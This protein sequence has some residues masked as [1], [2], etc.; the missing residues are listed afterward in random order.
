MVKMQVRARGEFFEFTRE[1]IEQSIAARFASQARRYPDRLAVAAAGAKLSYR[2]LDILSDRVASLLPLR[3]N[4]GARPVAVRC[5][6]TTS[7]AAAVLGV[8]K[9]G[10]FYVPLSVDTPEAAAE[11]IMRQLDDPIVVTEDSVGGLAREP[12]A[13]FTGSPAR[14]DDLAYVYFTSGTTGEPKGVTDQHRNVLHNIMRYTNGLRIGPEDRLS[15]LQPAG[16]SGAVSSLFSAIL[17]GAAVFPFDPARHSTREL[18]QWVLE[19]ELT[20]WHSVPSLFRQLCSTE[21]EFPSVRVIRLEGD[22]ASP[23]DI[24]LFRRHFTRECVLVNGLGATETGI[25]RR[26]VVGHDT[27]IRGPLLPVGFAVEDMEVSV[28]DQNGQRL[29]PGTI[30]EVEVRSRYLATGYWRRPDLTARAFRDCPGEPGVRAYRTGDLGRMREDGCLELTGRNDGLARLRGQWVDLAAI[31]EALARAP[32]VADAA[33]AVRHGRGGE[34]RLTAWIVPTPG[35]SAKVGDLRRHLAESLPGQ[36]LPSSIAVIERIPLD[37]HG[38]RDRSQLPLPGRER[39]LLGNAYVAPSTPEETRIAASFREILELDRVGLD[40]DFFELGGDSLDAARMLSG[41]GLDSREFFRQPSVRHLARVGA[42]RADNGLIS[43]LREGEDGPAWFCVPGHEGAFAGYVNL[44]KHLAPGPAVHA[45]HPAPFGDDGTVRSLEA[46]AALYVAELRSVQP[47]GPYRLS[48]LCFGGE[49][50]YEMACQLSAA[51][52]RVELLALIECVRE[53]W[54]DEQ[55]WTSRA[56]DW[57][58][59][60]SRRGAYHGRLLADENAGGRYLLSRARAVLHDWRES[61]QQHAFDRHL[62]RSAPLPEE[63]R[64][65]RFANRRAA[66]AW[67]PVPYAGRTL[68]F[69]PAD[70][71]AGFFDAP[72]LG[73]QGYLRGETEVIR[74]SDGLRGLLS[75]PVVAAIAER[76]SRVSSMLE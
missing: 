18:A 21:R 53:S 71:R 36:P 41:L 49:T 58:R 40:D 8:L 30:G 52:E 9:A 22:A 12:S 38:K 64:Q 10:H 44:A 24:E 4:G 39:P 34:P 59:H 63:L 62:E 6:Q 43:T 65:V 5:G 13:R 23:R 68:L 7:L 11:R 35:G 33:A 66:L 25:T 61:A 15:L 60:L 17:N 37:R 55:P 27:A 29:S 48:G 69:A 70:P 19:N 72:M 73:W 16:F 14:P 56:A 45:F 1:D 74:L 50:A 32:G 42:R 54:T 46:I 26:F 76:L 31:E 3:A 47:T 51:G 28:V 75:E 20:M 67:R 2:D 57:L